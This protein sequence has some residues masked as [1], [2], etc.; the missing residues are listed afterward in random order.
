MSMRITH[1]GSGSRGN[2]TLISSE[3]CNVLVDCGFSL[4]QTEKRLKIADVE[5]DSIDAIVVTHHHKDHSESA[6]RASKNWDASLHCNLG[7][8]TRMGWRPIEEC[9]TFGNLERID[10]S[11]KMSM[12]AIPV[13]HDDADNVALIASDGGGS[14]AA[15]VTD[16]GEVPQDL[17]TH[18][19][20]CNHIS[21]EANYDHARLM[22]CQYPDSLKRRIAGRGG[23]LS[24]AQTGEVLREVCHR[25]LQSLVLC[26]L[27]EKNNAP[28]LAE[29]EVLMAI[30]E[31]FQGNV[32]KSKQ[33]G[34]D[35]SYWTGQSEPC[36]MATA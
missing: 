28:H 6:L 23:H 34:P 14:R 15:I 3:E 27:S 10:F 19:S 9:K 22:G 2:A 30:G 31:R 13:P 1:L 20:S 4:R 35:F 29:S 25:N 16:L 5:P 11:S 8:A 18:L 33:T 36:R 32:S 17:V 7:T 24:N 21:I 26:H 12:L